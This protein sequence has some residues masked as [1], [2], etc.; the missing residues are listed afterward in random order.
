MLSI[1]LKKCIDEKLSEDIQF[2]LDDFGDAVLKDIMERL[3]GKRSMNNKEIKYLEALF[4]RAMD[5]KQEQQ[6]LVNNIH[7][8]LAVNTSIIH[9][10][11]D[12]C[13]RQVQ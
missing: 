11:D 9:H 7:S 10:V 8:H 1:A 5:Y 6:C 13:P 12:F 4:K 2:K 3:K